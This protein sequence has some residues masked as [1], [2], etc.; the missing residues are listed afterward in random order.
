MEKDRTGRKVYTEEE[1]EELGRKALAK[2]KITV[3]VVH[4]Q[5][6]HGHDISVCGGLKSAQR[7]VDDLMTQRVSE[8]WDQI[9]RDR[10]SAMTD[11][12]ERLDYFHAVEQNISYGESI[13][14]LERRVG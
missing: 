1:L 13:E 8:S 14:I 9:D 11:F 7:M 4:Y 2:H 10:I 12:G 6:K 5:H 3:Y